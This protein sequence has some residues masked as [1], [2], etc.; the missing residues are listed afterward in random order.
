LN[1]E[2]MITQLIFEVIEY[3]WHLYIY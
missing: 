2:V 3:F 1:G